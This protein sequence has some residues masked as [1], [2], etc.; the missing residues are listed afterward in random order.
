VDDIKEIT[1][2][3]VVYEPDVD[4]IKEITVKTVV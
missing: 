2:K 1:L 4:D 3:T